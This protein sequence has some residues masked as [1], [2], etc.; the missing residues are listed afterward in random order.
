MAHV[1]V[2][3]EAGAAYLQVSD[4]QVVETIE[5]L[6]GLLIDLDEL[7]CA[8]GVEVLSLGLEIPVEEITHRYHVRREDLAALPQM[9]PA[10]TSFVARQAA[11]TVE[12]G[13][14]GTLKVLAQA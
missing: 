8:V 9:R 12:Q 4:H 7:R 1:S 13:R 11:G 2:D 3:F 6:P 5:I 14:T 10:I